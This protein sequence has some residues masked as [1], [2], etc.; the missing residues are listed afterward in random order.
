MFIKLAR[1]FGGP[2][3]FP[4]LRWVIDECKKR[5]I[6]TLFFVARDGYILKG[7]TDRLIQCEKLNIK[8]HYIYGSR[9]V[10]RIGYF[11]SEDFDIGVFLEESYY[12]K[13]VNL[14]KLARLFLMDE[15]SLSNYIPDYYANNPSGWGIGD[16]F[17]IQRYLNNNE[18]FKDYLREKHKDLRIRV[19]KYIEQELRDCDLEKTAFVDSIGTG[20]TQYGMYLLSG[21][22]THIQSFYYC[23]DS[24]YLNEP[25]YSYVEDTSSSSLSI[26][27][28]CRSCEGQTVDYELHNGQYTPVFDEN[29]AKYLKEY[30]YETYIS[31]IFAMADDNMPFS[32][33][34]EKKAKS[35]YLKMH[36][37]RL[38]GLLGNCPYGVTGAEKEVSYYAPKLGIKDKRQ[39]YKYGFIHFQNNDYTG[40]DLPLSLKRNGIGIYKIREKI[41]NSSFI[42]KRQARNVNHLTSSNKRL[43]D[44]WPELHKKKLIVYGAGEVGTFLVRLLVGDNDVELVLWTDKREIDSNLFLVSKVRKIED[45]DFDYIIIAAINYSVAKQ[46]YNRVKTFKVDDDKI[47]M[48]FSSFS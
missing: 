13:I 48:G 22:K 43:G 38:I 30:G 18:H 28:L 15:E 26:E 40:A 42:Q 5:N 9:K 20:Y 1:E 8:T 41:L 14:K 17:L 21:Q 6:D 32:E 12:H 23:Q 27:I 34:D 4:Y 39:L 37:K 33:K 24:K 36:D 11:F 16:V 10:W 47:L 29:E 7:I 19:K 3:L 25:Y 35:R 46:I 44:I 45:S 2:I 31:E